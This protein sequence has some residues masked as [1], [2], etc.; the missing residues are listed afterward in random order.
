MKKYIMVIDEGTTGTRALIYNKK[1]EIVSQSYVEFMQYTP[2]EDKV[3]HDAVEIYEK[4]I[5]R[6][7]DAMERAGI[8]ADD[9]AAIGITNQRATCVVWDKNTGKPLYHAIVWQDSRTA[10]DCNEINESGMGEKVRKRT[11]W[12]VGPVYTSMMMKWYLDNVPEIKKAVEAGDAL[13]GT[14]DTW[15]IWNLTGGKV[16][17]VSYSNASVMGSYDL[18]TGDWYQE[19]LDYLGI[20]VSIYPE[21][22]DDSGDFGSTDPELFGAPI[23]ITSAIADQHAA[24]FAQGCTKGGSGKITNGTGSFLDINVGSNRDRLY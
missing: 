1:F 6:C 5:D 21:V 3:E 23:P 20:P 9:I 7:K 14:I 2:A 12:T 24:L 8:M 13:M 16:H 19:F 4:T 17:A 22:R 10:V 11:G 18:T 15:L